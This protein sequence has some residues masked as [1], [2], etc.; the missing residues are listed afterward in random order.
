MSR[1]RTNQAPGN[2]ELH[3]KLTATRTEWGRRTHLPL[4]EF[5][6]VGVASTV[7]TFRALKTNAGDENVVLPFRIID[8]DG[9]FR[10]IYPITIP[11]G[12]WS[13]DFAQADIDETNFIGG[14]LTGTAQDPDWDYLIF[15]HADLTAAPGSEFKGFSIITYPEFDFTAISDGSL[16]ALAV[17]DVPGFGN[18][19]NVGARVIV[20]EGTSP[21]NPYNQGE[22]TAK[23]ADTITVQLD[24]DSE[25]GVAITGSTGTV[26]QTSHFAPLLQADGLPYGGYS[27]VYMGSFQADSDSDILYFRKREEFYA[28]DLK[29]SI[30]NTITSLTPAAAQ[31]TAARIVPV[32]VTRAHVWIR[33]GRVGTAKRITLYNE[34]NG[35]SVLLGNANSVTTDDYAQ[36]DITLRSRDVSVYA[37]YAGSAL[38]SAQYEIAVNGYFPREF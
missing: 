21:T 5:D 24:N 23:T 25:Y 6:P 13:I 30:V 19:Y 12:L 14:R 11:D 36:A 37:V 18:R 9:V 33:T 35:L 10:G 17:I 26:V 38:A 28:F 20:R 29:L 32:G 27:Y 1:T 4:F 7:L 31:V 34:L 15:A 22:I 16:G 3:S 2:S 8:T